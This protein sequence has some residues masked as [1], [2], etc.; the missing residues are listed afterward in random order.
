M[1]FLKLSEIIGTQQGIF[2]AGEISWNE[3]TLINSAIIF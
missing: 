2:S 1:F 3:D